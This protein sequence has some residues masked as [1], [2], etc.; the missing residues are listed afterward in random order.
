MQTVLG[1]KQPTPK[2][3]D[4]AKLSSTEK[5]THLT[6]QEAAIRQQREDVESEVAREAERIRRENVT[7]EMDKI[8]AERSSIEQEMRD[9]Q[10]ELSELQKVV[11]RM[12]AASERYDAAAKAYENLNASAG[13]RL[14]NVG[15]H[16]DEIS[17][18]NAEAVRVQ[19][20]S[21]VCVQHD[22]LKR[23]DLYIGNFFAKLRSD[24]LFAKLA[25][26]DFAPDTFVLVL[27][28]IDKQ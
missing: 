15:G 21:T 10:S 2:K 7:G 20:P 18:F 17:G 8:R 9:A 4:F 3:V 12:I 26:I 24:S 13:L 14:S 16:V 28:Q 11:G 27:R 5:I 22:W 6:E 1:L 19:T 25:R 23:Y